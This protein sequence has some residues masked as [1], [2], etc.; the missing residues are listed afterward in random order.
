M[1]LVK[2]SKCYACY[3]ELT[4]VFSNTRPSVQVSDDEL[5]KYLEII[6]K[7]GAIQAA[8]NSA[9]KAR[10]VVR[11]WQRGDSLYILNLLERSDTLLYR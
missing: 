4:D 1:P 5:Q 2:E 6:D 3:A 8:A 10:E 9:N 7:T 11:H